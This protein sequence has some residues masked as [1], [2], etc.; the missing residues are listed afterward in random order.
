[1]AKKKEENAAPEADASEQLG[2]GTEGLSQEEKDSIAAGGEDPRYKDVPAGNEPILN[3]SDAE[4]ETSTADL[5]GVETGT[6]EPDTEGKEDVLET[7]PVYSEVLHKPTGDAVLAL[8]RQIKDMSGQTVILKGG[9]P[10]PV[11]EGTFVFNQ[12]MDYTEAAAWLMSHEDGAVR[13]L[14]AGGGDYAEVGFLNREAVNE[15][16]AFDVNDEQYSSDRN[17]R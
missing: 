12:R 16:Q 10:E 13:N 2:E 6:D 11:K 4:G 17:L 1:M 8:A 7:V 15:K 3:A 9:Q 5:S 14:P